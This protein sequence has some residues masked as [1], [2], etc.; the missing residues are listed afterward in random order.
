MSAPLT[1]ISALTSSTVFVDLWLKEL[2]LVEKG[3]VKVKGI[4]E[5]A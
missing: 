5:G 4:L 3:M 2:D 1:T